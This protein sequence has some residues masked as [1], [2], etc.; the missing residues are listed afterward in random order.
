MRF[1][2]R[3]YV[4]DRDVYVPRPATEDLAR[5]AASLLRSGGAALDL[6]T[7]SGVIAAHLAAETP[8]ATVIGTDVD[9]VAV[10]CAHQNG[11]AALVADLAAPLR[12]GPWFDVVTAVA[13]YV[14][15]EAIRLLPVDVQR[16]EPRRAL[17]GG[18][19][20][21]AIVRRVVGEAA[22]VLRPGGSLLVEIGGV[23]DV[24]LTDTLAAAG[25]VDV[26]PWHDE[27]GDL[28][29]LAATRGEGD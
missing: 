23:Q 14:P 2:D 7:G 20:G 12:D 4:I 8:S 24:D 18:P 28:R 27:D 22:R 3:W 26:A 19:D 21:G 10:R 5:R 25:F 1:C 9:P 17:D 16:H 29:G 15:T 11:V 13:P 6:C